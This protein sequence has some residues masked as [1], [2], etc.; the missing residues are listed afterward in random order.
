MDNELENLDSQIPDEELN[1]DL[2][3][4]QEET[5]QQ[6]DED[7]EALKKQL[8]DSEAK[9]A[10]LHA[11]LKRAGAEKPKPIQSSDGIDDIKA[12]VTQL[13][14]KDKMLDFGLEHGLSREEVNAVFKLNQNPTKETLEDPFVKGGLQAIRAKTAVKDAI[15]GS[16]KRSPTIAGKSF[17]DMSKEE[18]AKNWSTIIAKSV[19]R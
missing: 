1:L 17:A 2:E 5:P 13:A 7:V 16:S 10:Q 14:L 18:K 12:T 19:G 8:A 9:R 15:P 11:R 6:A 4:E 3:P